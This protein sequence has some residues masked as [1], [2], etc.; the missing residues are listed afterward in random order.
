MVKG[1]IKLLLDKV[2]KE[3][4]RS[5]DDK[6]GKLKYSFLEKPIRKIRELFP[7]R[8]DNTTTTTNT[9]KTK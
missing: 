9:S 8:E 6:A 2:R 7:K 5:Q 4:N 3:K 1:D